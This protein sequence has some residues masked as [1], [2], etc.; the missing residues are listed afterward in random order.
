MPAGVGAVG[1]SGLAIRM[2]AR[3]SAPTLQIVVN[4]LA[5]D[6]EFAGDSLNGYSRLVVDDDYVDLI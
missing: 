6:I 1:S 2:P 5:V 4:G 3:W